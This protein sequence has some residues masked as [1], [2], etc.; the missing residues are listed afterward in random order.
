MND[1]IRTTGRQSVCGWIPTLALTLVP[2]AASAEPVPE[3]V[4]RVVVTATGRNRDELRVPQFTTTISGADIL[5][6][7]ARTVPEALQEEVGILVQETNFG[8]G[9]PFLRGQTGN[10]VLVLVDGVRLNNSTFRFGPNQYLNTID[11][12]TVERIEVVRGPASVLHGSDALGGVVHVI[13]K[14]RLDFDKP[15]D[16]DASTTSRLGSAAFEKTMRADGSANAGPFGIVGGVTYRHF[17]DLRSGSKVQDHT[18]YDELAGD[19]RLQYHI[20]PGHEAAFSFQRVE[21]NRVPRTGAFENGDEYFFDPQRRSLYALEYAASD[22]PYGF[23]TWH[24]TVSFHDQLEVR[25]RL[26]AAAMRRRR[27]EDGVRTIG[28]VSD[29]DHQPMEGVTLTAGVEVYHDEV[30]S[31]RVDTSTTNGAATV[32]R[33]AFPDG[34]TYDTLGVFLQSELAV[35]DLISESLPLSLILGGRYSRFAVDSAPEDFEPVEQAFD[36]IVGSVA[37][38]YDLSRSVSLVASVSQGFRA[39]NLDDTV[40]LKEEPDLG[41][42]D[43]PNPDLKPEQVLNYEGGVKFRT[44]RL[45]GQAFYFFADYEDLIER[46]TDGTGFDDANGNGLQD[47]GELTYAQRR[48]IGEAVIQG[49]EATGDVLLGHGVTLAMQVSWIRGENRTDDEPVRRIPPVL[50]RAGLR[51]DSRRF[52]YWIEFFAR[53]AG[54]QD[55]LASGDRTDP[56]ICPDGPEDCDDTPGWHTLNL[57]GGW[58]PSDALELNLALENLTDQR[59]RIHGS[60]L[61]APGFNAVGTLA[62]HF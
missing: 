18:G 4:E 51:Y 58:R 13:T 21:Q 50:G 30:S 44:E 56:R 57:R 36:K 32:Q 46:T 48:N 7:A 53:V 39:P 22:L 49:V 17:D 25:Q 61:D 54:R 9:S 33:G 23:R 55:R 35:G 29:I 31:N 40:V 14:R 6:K 38:I 62:I 8:G 37:A 15:F 1:R 42:I 20:A 16:L 2:F 41:V 52:P 43:S 3:G 27:E 19:L 26:E 11:P 5:E 47:P 59:Y 60:G 28:F 45:R 24:T 34:T 12:F 10:R